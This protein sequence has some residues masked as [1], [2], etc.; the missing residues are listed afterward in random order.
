MAAISRLVQRDGTFYFRMAT[1]QRL[2]PVIGRREIKTSLRTR[3]PL[4]AKVT[5]RAL[6][7]AF[8]VLFARLG[9]M[10]AVPVADINEKVREY[11]QSALNQ[12]LEHSHLLPSDP[13]VDLGAEVAFLRQQVDRLR[14]QL[15]EQSFGPAIV[16]DA[17]GLVGGVQS[18]SGAP[19]HIDHDALNL[20][21][22][23]IMRAKIENARILAAQLEGR[24]DETSPRDPLFAGMQPNGL[25]PIGEDLPPE[26]E[27]VTFG[28]LC[29]RFYAFKKAGGAADKT[30]LDIE[31]VNRLARAKIKPEKDVKKI[32][33]EDMRRMRDHVATLK[34]A[35]GETVSIVTQ[36]KYF[37]FFKA[38]I[39][40]GV[41]EAH[42]PVMPGEKI[43]IAGAS[44]VKSIDQRRP[45]SPDQLKAIFGSSLYTGC[46][47]VV[48]RH[49]PGSKVI[50]DGYW[51]TP[52]I[53]LT[54]GMRL[55]EIIQLDTADVKEEGG[56]TYFDIT[57]TEGDGKRLKTASSA[58]RVP[59][60]AILF[61]LGFAEMLKRADP[62]RRLFEEVEIGKTGFPS[63]AFSKWWGR[64]AR[65]VGFQE[66]RTAFHSFR[67]AFA[68]GCRD[69]GVPDALA[70][71]VMGHTDGSVHA[72]YGSKPPV[73][74]LKEAID[75]VK[76]PAIDPEK[77][78]GKA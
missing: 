18:A 5:A 9:T 20:A 63:H 56:I 74:L 71:A 33:A 19:T 60:P 77:L 16:A 8:D 21:C 64:F 37:R 36:E 23:G 40:W 53:A 12:S 50:R 34:M 62:K 66:D 59:V 11:F 47:S 30:L 67:H 76:F 70:K 78:V 58:R 25:P 54:T 41:D 48:R 39:R 75:R 57:K 3:D 49:K 43:K 68:D 61:D 24:Y 1:P 32:D 7:N 2:I 28:D 10:P 4:T 46:E 6:S 69:A 55:G 65:S 27:T 15:A 22:S 14:Q 52:L 51:W 42:I 29:E 35:N 38:L 45:Y 44:K 26:P 17:H 13:T 31:R 72:L 73:A